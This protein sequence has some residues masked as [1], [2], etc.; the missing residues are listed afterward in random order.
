M[1]ST[2]KLF[3]QLISLAMGAFLF[4]TTATA[5]QPAKKQVSA[6]EATVK[7]ATSKKAAMCVDAGTENAMVGQVITEAMW[8]SG[9][10]EYRDA[11]VSLS[12]EYFA[13]MDKN[14]KV[15]SFDVS[16]ASKSYRGVYVPNGAE[17]A[18]D[19]LILKQVGALACNMNSFLRENAVATNIQKLWK[20]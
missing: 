4:A 15:K 6:S 10:Q 2:K 9:G 12:Y 11:L 14:C 1:K 20:M 3:L 18:R 5:A 17:D 13:K 8:T 19:K 16:A 7:K